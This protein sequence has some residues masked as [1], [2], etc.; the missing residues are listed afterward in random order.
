MPRRI[1][2]I[3][4]ELA[5]LSLRI[6]TLRTREDDVQRLI[7]DMKKLKDS[8]GAERSDLEEQRRL[9]EVERQPVNRIPDEILAEL[10][11]AVVE[12]NTTH[13][14]GER[15]QEGIATPHSR[16]PQVPLSHVCQRWRAVA[17]STPSLWAKVM[18]RESLSGRQHDHDTEVEILRLIIQRSGNLPVDI[19]YENPSNFAPIGDNQ[20]LTCILRAISSDLPRIRSISLKCCNPRALGGVVMLVPNSMPNLETPH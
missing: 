6:Y 3:E 9:L 4:A 18:Y 17:L 12:T 14:L 16:W 15:W 1:S 10:L 2:I 8:L 20:G 19:D 13:V 7:D 5:K 11:S